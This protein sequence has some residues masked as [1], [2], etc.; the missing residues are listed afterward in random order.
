[1][2]ALETCPTHE[3]TGL[4]FEE[5]GVQV[6]EA[7]VAEGSSHGVQHLK[8]PDLNTRIEA[9]ELN[10]KD[11][12]Q[13]LEAGDAECS[14]PS[15]FHEALTYN[16]EENRLEGLLEEELGV[17]RSIIHGQGEENEV[18]CTSTESEKVQEEKVEE[19]KVEESLSINGSNALNS[20]ISQSVVKDVHTNGKAENFM[21]LNLH[22]NT[23]YMTS[24]VEENSETLMDSNLGNF[25]SMRKEKEW[26]RTL[27]CKLF[28]ERH[29]A[30]GGSE[31][32]GEGMDLLWEAYESDTGKMQ[33][34]NK[35][36]KK[37]KKNGTKY[38][39]EEDEE[40]EET[41]VQLCCL[42]A[43]KF[44]SGKMNLGMGRPN[45]VRITKALKGFGWLHH[46]SKN[47]KKGYY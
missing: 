25:G 14:S 13:V 10:L 19:E 33:G 24:K 43:L 8:E 12:I 20:K 27:A 1:M 4:K 2:V 35:T 45:L 29:N 44:S 26:K 15:E 42:Q 46:V 3:A 11:G 5:N 28:E 7:P 40:E 17:S 39:H 22:G 30:N 38:N 47:G 37:G 21:G 32:E 9:T 41:D 31:G 16:L 18:K 36:E 34:K 23:E 6:L